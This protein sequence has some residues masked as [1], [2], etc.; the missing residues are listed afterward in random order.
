VSAPAPTETTVKE[1][2]RANPHAPQGSSASATR[3]A[4]ASAPR[5]LNL[6][7]LKRKLE[8]G[9]ALLP[10]YVAVFIRQCLWPVGSEFAAWT[11]TALLSVLVWLA[12]LY[13]K[14]EVGGR[15]PRSFWLVVALPLFLIYAMRAPFPDL[16]FDVLNHRLIQGERALRGPQLLPGDF[17]PT[18]FP[19]NPSSDMLAGLFRHLLGYRLGTI[20]NLLVL[21][22]T[23]TVV[24]KLLRP[25][26]KRGAWRSACVLLVL[27]TEHML[28]E[29]NNYMVDLL[30]L[31][32]AL[33]ALRLALRYD[34]SQTKGRDLLFSAL[35]LGACVGLKLTNAA[36]VVPIAAVFA[37]RIFSSRLDSRTLGFVALACALF[38][39]PIWPHAL[40]IWRETGNPVFPLY[41][42]LFKSPL[43]PDLSPYDGRWGPRDWGETLLWPLLS[44]RMPERLSELKVYSGRLTLASVAALL[45]L[46]LPRVASSVRLLALAALLGSFVW[47]ATSGYVRYALFVEITGGVLLVALARYAWERASRLP[48]AAR[49][50]AASLPVCLLVAQCVLA[51]AY[52][53]QTEWSARPTIFDDAAGYRRELRWVWRDRDLM[54]F[55][56]EENKELF[57]RVDAWVVSG[58]KSNGIE[59]LLRP[60]VP[61]VGIV[62]IEYFQKWQSRR[63]FAPKLEALR[64]KRVYTLTTADE[65][66]ASLAALRRRKFT[67]GEIRS[68]FVPF[69]SARTRVPMSLIEVFPPER[70][71]TPRRS[72]TDPEVSESDAPLDEDAFVAGLT[73]SDAPVSMSRGQKATVHVVVKNLS[74]Y[75]WRARGRADGK[76][77][78]NAANIWL[79]ADGETLVD[80]TDGRAN[81][82]RDLWPGEEAVV[83][84]QIT[85]PAEP[86]EYVL[87]LDLVQEQVAFFKGEGSETWRT[88]VKVE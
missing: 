36:V 9:D 78:L 52:V 15:T 24:E 23:G 79:A 68:V 33:E 40:Y 27:F 65:L 8:F 35:L 86:G 11:L 16:S 73:A 30:A 22:W 13:T 82:P 5:P 28:F 1:T 32:L 55:Q 70:R 12:Y 42:D 43:W 71:E 81:L 34:E 77:Q 75:V 49:L 83:P 62:Y 87:E 21:V 26:V 7:S 19:F 37:V 69:F 41:N 53:R 17:F 67:V 44:A 80:N 74:Q 20:I 31:P 47:G 2:R 72:P 25:F 59:A 54:K 38:L 64:G 46:L 56:T 84:L 50:A 88:R 6:S 76:Y 60:R 48:R 39:L 63:L 14:P 66:D 10:F 58:V 61:S 45:C 18:I 57:A 85:A 4:G 29:V 51:G 3:R